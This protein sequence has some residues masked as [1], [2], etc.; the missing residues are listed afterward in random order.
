MP[1]IPARFDY[2]L[3]TLYIQNTNTTRLDI[4]SEHISMN[5][6]WTPADAKTDIFFRSETL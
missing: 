3:P 2:N 1:M 5:W 4:F 6:I